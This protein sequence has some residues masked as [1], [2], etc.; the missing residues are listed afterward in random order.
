[1]MKKLLYRIRYKKTL[2]EPK[3]IVVWDVE[4][5]REYVTDKFHMENCTVEMSYGNSIQQEKRC[6]AKVILEIFGESD[7]N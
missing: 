5:N 3:R 1:M 7:R 4:N 2:Q 6:G